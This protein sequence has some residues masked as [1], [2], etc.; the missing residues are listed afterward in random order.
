MLEA[1]AD[2]I[3]AGQVKPIGKAP[4]YLCTEEFAQARYAGCALPA[5]QC[6]RCICGGS[7]A[8]LRL[9]VTGYA[10]RR[11]DEVPRGPQCI[12]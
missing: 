3:L 5:R 10:C 1:A 9:F 7:R 2:P 6:V 11:P 8:V 12:R 4:H